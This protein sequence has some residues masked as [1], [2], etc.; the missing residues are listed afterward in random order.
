MAPFGPSGISSSKSSSISCSASDQLAFSEMTAT[1]D[2]G[3]DAVFAKDEDES[4]DPPTGVDEDALEPPAVNGVAA[5]FPA[6]RARGASAGL[7]MFL[8]Y[9]LYPGVVDSCSRASDRAPRPPFV[10]DDPRPNDARRD[11]SDGYFKLAELD[12]SF[13]P[14]CSSPT[15]MSAVASISSRSL[16]DEE[17]K[18]TSSSDDNRVTF[19][20]PI[21]LDAKFEE[22]DGVDID[23]AMTPVA[24][25]AVADLMEAA[26]DFPPPT[27]A[28]AI[29]PKSGSRKSSK[30]S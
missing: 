25:V 24:P 13:V 17:S 9:K 18:S 5:A 4:A 6:I 20:L 14:K 1:D 27:V 22:L 30:K 8:P 28:I 12:E 23:P 11:E 26:L 2:T 15:E 10:A 7:E 16:S 29:L 3:T 19:D 21:R